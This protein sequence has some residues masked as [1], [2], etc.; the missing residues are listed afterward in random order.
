MISARGGGLWSVILPGTERA[1]VGGLIERWL[2]TRKPQ[3]YCAFVGARSS[4]QHAV[5]RAA[6]LSAREHMI[7]IVPKDWRQDAVEQLDGRGVGTILYEPH[8]AGT[9]AQLYASL[10]YVRAR[11]P[12][13]TAV[14]Y[15]SDHFFYPEHRFLASVQHAAAAAEWLPDRVMLLAVPPEGLQLEYPWVVPGEV[16]AGSAKGAVKSVQRMVSFATPAEADDALAQGGLWHTSV[17]AA[18]TELLWQLGWE[19]IPELMVRFEQLHAA[20]GTAEEDAVLQRMYADMPY[21]D[22]LADLVSHVVKRSAVI[23]M[24]SVLWSDW[25]APERITHT[26]RRIGREP[27]FPL[28]CLTKP[29]VPIRPAHADRLW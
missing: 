11:D 18:K 24:N 15:P 12:Y 6:V 22:I 1:G 19:C 10:A 13:S 29:F 28:A 14:I 17:F 8:A 2:G 26:L 3:E 20:I 16:L 23:E 27:A 21:R 25:G 4:F 9:L 5:D 7:A